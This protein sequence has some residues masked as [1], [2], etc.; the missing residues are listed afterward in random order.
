MC[1]GFSWNN[2]FFSSGNFKESRTNLNVSKQ[3]KDSSDSKKNQV[4]SMNWWVGVSHMGDLKKCFWQKLFGCFFPLSVLL[5]ALVKRLCFSCMRDFV[6]SLSEMVKTEFSMG[7]HKFLPPCMSENIAGCV[8]HYS[9][10]LVT[11]L[12]LSFCILA[13]NIYDQNL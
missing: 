4:L 3:L 8:R 7:R 11:V 5:F 13:Q 2:C 1:Q 12:F 9:S 6:Y 10:Q